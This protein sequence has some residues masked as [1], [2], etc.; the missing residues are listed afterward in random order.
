MKLTPHKSLWERSF[1]WSPDG[2]RIVAGTFDGTVVIWDASTGTL[3]KE[4]GTSEASDGNTCFND[5]ASLDDGRLVT[6][7][8]DGIVRIGFLSEDLAEWRS[9]VTPDSGRVLMNA[10]TAEPGTSMIATGTHNQHVQT[11]KAEQHHTEQIQDVR[12]GEGPI[13]CI[14]YSNHEG[15]EGHMFVACYSGKVTHLDQHGEIQHR[16]Q[17]HENAVKSLRL[18][19]SRPLGVSGSADG[20]LA[21]WRFDGSIYRE[22]MGHTS[23]IDDV[24]IDPT[25]QFIA[26][27]GRDFILKVHD[28]E[29]G[30]LLHTISLGR[31]SPKALI[32]LEENVVIVTN[33]WGEL[34][35][36]DLTD[37]SMIRAQVAKNGISAIVRHGND[38]A[39]ASYDG[40]IYLVSSDDLRVLSH[41]NAMVQ[42][43]ED[44]VYV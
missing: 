5:V 25:G 30:N 17:V 34:I 27:A 15:F 26:S 4:V 1:N 32:F 35:R 21:T 28:L 39:A 12:L 24:D 7:S 29:G 10:V 6:V 8:D 14:R 9:S 37:E 23:I 41:L 13:N 38:L 18:H 42:H 43:V 20:I 2:D 16:M 22:Y 40:N 36:V 31:R 33:Y 11:F 19:P 44:P 3:L